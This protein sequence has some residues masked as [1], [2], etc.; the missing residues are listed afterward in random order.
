MDSIELLQTH[1]PTLSE[2]QVDLFKKHKVLFEDWNSKIN[3]IS[4]K[5]HPFFC[6]KAFFAAFPIYF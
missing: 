4:R 3:M 6:G 2:K 5:R 1:F